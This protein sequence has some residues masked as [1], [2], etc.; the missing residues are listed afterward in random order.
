MNNPLS[1]ESG[2]QSSHAAR[3]PEYYLQTIDPEIRASFT[4]EQVAAIRHVLTI[5]IPK[6]APKLVDLRFSVDLILSRF[7]VVLLVGKDR[8]KQNRSYLPE[9]VARLGNTL[10]A[11]V[12]LIGLN[13][14]ITLV[15][16]LFVYLAKSAIG[17]DLFPSE[18]LADQ[19][20]KLS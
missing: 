14:L 11:I 8:R 17:I 19:L 1:Y 6:P 16:M 20:K 7:Y 12:L 18:H 9:P 2:P 15:L 4:P 5:A 3:P 13:L 10:A